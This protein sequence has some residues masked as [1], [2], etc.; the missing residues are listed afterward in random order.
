MPDDKIAITKHAGWRMEQRAVRPEDIALVVC[1]GKRMSRDV[2]LL[3]KSD[4]QR[5]IAD[6]KERINW[7]ERMKKLG[8]LIGAEASRRVCVLKAEVARFE[9]LKGLK[10]VVEDGV[11]VTCY[12]LSER[13]QNQRRAFRRGRTRK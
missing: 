10:V 2:W 11:L 9:R 5:G 6:V 3:R 8:S 7:V 4:A 1:W 12:W 13:H